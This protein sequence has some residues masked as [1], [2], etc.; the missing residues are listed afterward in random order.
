M[1]DSPETITINGVEYVKKGSK[2]DSEYVIVRTYSAGVFFGKIKERNG[3][4][5]TV[6]DARRLWY[7]KG[8]A[9]LSQMALEGV[10]CPRECKFPEAVPEVTL[11]EIIEILPCTA[12]AIKS[13]QGVPIW[14]A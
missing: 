8:A 3:K 10:S 11:T 5:G 12:E 13:L 6:V 4:E 1:T 14:K 9:S 2:I 7:W